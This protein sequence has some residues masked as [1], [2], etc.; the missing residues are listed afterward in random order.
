MHYAICLFL[1]KLPPPDLGDR[2]ILCIIINMHY[3]YMH[4]KDFNCT[5]EH[6]TYH[7][8]ISPVFAGILNTSVFAEMGEYIPQS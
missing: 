1:Y 3:K 8:V 6:W 5:S 7:I 2:E 4:Y